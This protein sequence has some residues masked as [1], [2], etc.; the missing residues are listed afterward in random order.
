MTKYRPAPFIT[1]NLLQTQLFKQ[2]FMAFSWIT[3]S[4]K[5]YEVGMEDVG[6]PLGNGAYIPY[7]DDD[8]RNMESR[9]AL[10]FY[11]S[12]GTLQV[13]RL[14][15]HGVQ[16]TDR[17][18]RPPD[19]GT[20]DDIRGVR[21]R[22]DHLPLPERFARFRFEFLTLDTADCPLS[23]TAQASCCR[24]MDK[25][26]ESLAMHIENRFPHLTP[27]QR[28]MRALKCT[29]LLPSFNVSTPFLSAL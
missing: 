24:V 22:Q 28:T 16:E 15:W 6:I 29:L 25:L 10:L 14:L 11:S 2:N 1:E 17:L 27:N 5:C 13:G 21:P 9:Y 8:Q 19:E 4:Y 7:K 23:E 12:Y 26:L 3:Y 18:D 20:P